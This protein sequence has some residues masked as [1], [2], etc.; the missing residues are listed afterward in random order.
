MKADQER[1]PYSIFTVVYSFKIIDGK[2]NDFVKCWTALTKYIYKFEGSH[3]SRLHELD[4]NSFMAYAQWPDKET[5]ER[6]GK[7]RPA[8]ILN[9]SKQMRECCIEIKTEFQSETVICDLLKDISNE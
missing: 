2:S 5:F 4:G 9:I 7:N 6:S 1:T 8:E 3:G